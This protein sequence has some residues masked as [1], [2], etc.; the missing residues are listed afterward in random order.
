MKRRKRRSRR[1][2]TVKKRSRKTHDEEAAG[3]KQGAV[4]GKDYTISKTFIVCNHKVE[5]LLFAPT[6]NGGNFKM[7]SRTLRL[8]H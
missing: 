3:K 6:P 4:R 2:C 1:H 8:C 5:L 7:T